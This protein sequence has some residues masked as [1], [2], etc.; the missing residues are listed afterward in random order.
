MP[1]H[2]TDRA[3]GVSKSAPSILKFFISGTG[4]VYRIFEA[5]FLRR[6]E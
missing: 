2:F 6:F 5:R 4:Y 3:K 1:Y